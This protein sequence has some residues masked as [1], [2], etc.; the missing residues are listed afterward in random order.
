MELYPYGEAKLRLPLRLKEGMVIL[1]W[2]AAHKLMMPCDAIYSLPS[3][4][5]PLPVGR[6]ERP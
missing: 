1:G 4:R 5:V 6:S 3:A 2:Y